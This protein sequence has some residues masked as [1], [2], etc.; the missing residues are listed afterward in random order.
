MEIE[1]KFVLAA[2]P[3]GLDAREHAR[4]EQGYVALDD[5]GTEVRIRLRNALGEST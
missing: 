5:N 1:R 3:A 4:I 2:P